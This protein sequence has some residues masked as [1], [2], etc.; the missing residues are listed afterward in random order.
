MNQRG[1]S[2]MAICRCT[3][4]RGGQCAPPKLTGRKTLERRT[5]MPTRRELA[6][7]IRVLAMDA[8][9]Q[10]NSGHPGA[11]MGMADIAEVL[12]RDFLKHNPANPHWWNRDRFMLSNGHASMLLYAAAAPDRLSARHGRDQAISASSAAA[13]PGIPEH[14][15]DIG[16]ETT[17][18]PLGQG[19]GQRRR[20]RARR[21][22]AR[23]AVQP[24]RAADRR[25]PHLG[26]LR[27]RLP[28]GR[29]LAR[30][31]LAGRHAEARQADRVLRRQRHLDRR[32]GRRAG[33]P[34]T[35]PSASRPTAGTCR[36][37][38][39]MD[40]EAIAR[41]HSRGAGR[42]RSAPR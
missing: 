2:P 29:H 9:Q 16:I 24:S 40:G 42:D 4:A 27:R 8:V 31:L 34:T 23:G 3:P 18:G 11:P 10:A 25:S 32:Q 5:A 19:A 37:W 26:V 20:L 36:A 15:L 21:E 33:S 12:W 22:D 6:N 41:G 28:D 30:G 7:V 1:R 39:G 13:S 35:P 17:T 14:D 38:T